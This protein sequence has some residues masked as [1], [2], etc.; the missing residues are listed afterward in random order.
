MSQAL[1]CFLDYLY[2]VL[3]SLIDLIKDVRYDCFRKNLLYQ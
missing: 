2:K 3:K 1:F